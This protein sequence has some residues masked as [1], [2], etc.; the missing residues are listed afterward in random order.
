[1]LISKFPFKSLRYSLLLKS[2]A[3]LVPLLLALSVGAGMRLW[4]VAD[5]NRPGLMVDDE[6]FLSK[7]DG[8]GWLAGAKRINQHSAT[9]FSTCIRILHEAT[10]I[11]L[12]RIA[13]W[14]PAVLA[15]LAALPVCLLVLWWGI[16]EAGI[17]AGIMASSSIGYF[18]RTRIT[19]LDTDLISLFFPLCLAVG[20]IIWIESLAPPSRGRGCAP[21]SGAILFQAF[22]LGLLYRCYI[23]F[24]PSGETVGLSILALALM[25]GIVLSAPRFRLLMA[26]GILIVCLVGDG[27]WQETALAV[28]VVVLTVLRPGL[29]ARKNA[30]IALLL[31]LLVALWWFSDFGAKASDIW[32]HLSRYGR[33]IDSAGMAILP[34]A[35]ET[36]PEAWPVSLDG[37]V[38]FLAGNWPL[39]IAGITGLAIVLW[40]HPC[41]LLLLPLLALGLASVR[42]GIRFTMYGG[43]VLGI[44]MACGTALWLRAVHVPRWGSI[45]AQLGLLIAICWP[46]VKTVDAVHPEPVISKPLVSALLELKQR[47]APDA[48]VWVWWDQGYEVQYYGERMTFSDGYR[49]S[50]EEIFPLA[51]VHTAS[52]PLSAYQMI[53]RCSL[54]Q[55]SAGPVEDQGA[56]IPI[57]SNPFPDLMQDMSPEDIRLFLLGLKR[58]KVAWSHDLPEQYIVLTWKGLQRAHTILS[59]G[60]WDFVKGK[61]GPGIFMMFRERVGFDMRNG[62]MKVRNRVYH[63]SS[64]DMIN[65]RRGRPFTW[66]RENGWHAILRTTDGFTFLMD[67]AAYHT[68]MVQMLLTEPKRFE[69]YFDLLV[70]RFPLVRIYR[71]NPIL[72][73]L[74]P[75]AV[76]PAETNHAR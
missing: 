22:L 6:V 48:Q 61:S 59:Y 42:L 64:K 52:S 2:S 35:I 76:L 27:I 65:G 62:S 17:V 57:Y 49:N 63:L 9:P 33:L 32:F 19:C 39:F 4:E 45:A 74:P 30:A 12:D 40:K 15:P 72:I 54:L 50:A 37:A 20:M 55:Q 47:S 60:T 69:P 34:P 67:D 29:F 71:V 16:P 3:W 18:I 21:S 14:L 11:P 75:G 1:M 8:Y 73:D 10:D 51:Y 24:Y 43:S 28:G 5:W 31:F 56:R 7:H 41:T 68:M 58:P 23:A 36:V 26:G 38:F 66:Q 46:L 70:D 53:V 13:F 25:T 44:G